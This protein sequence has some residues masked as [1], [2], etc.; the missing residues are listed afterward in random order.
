[1]I[2]L[3]IAHKGVYKVRSNLIHPVI[4]ISIFRE[5]SLYNVIGYNALFVADGLYLCILDGR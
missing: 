5:I 3:D 1:M 4:I 2:S